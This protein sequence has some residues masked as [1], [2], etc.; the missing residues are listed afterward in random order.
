VDDDCQKAISNVREDLGQLE[1]RLLTQEIHIE[2]YKDSVSNLRNDFMS[3]QGSLKIDIERLQAS[4]HRDIKI[5]QDT[6]NE[7]VKQQ[8]V[9]EAKL[10]TGTGIGKVLID[11]LPWLIAVGA[12][13][14][15]IVE[16]IK[17]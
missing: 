6:L 17:R 3:L 12:F 10:S 11:K 14:V 5:L 16:V 2:H 8:A 1:K 4:L 13:F 7:I 9:D 15:A